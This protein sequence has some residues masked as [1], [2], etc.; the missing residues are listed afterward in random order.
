VPRIG[1]NRQHLLLLA[2]QRK[3]V[4]A[5]LLVPK[6]L[7]EVVEQRCCLRSQLLGTAVLAKLSEYFGHAPPG[8]VDVALQFAESL[9]PAY[10][11]PVRVDHAV[12]GVLPAH[13]LVADRRAGL[14][15]L[16]SI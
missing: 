13:V 3:G 14:I 5:Q 15:F 10:Q 8:V 7:I 4:A 12:S 2:V 11:R 16:K 1:G 9:W 6:R